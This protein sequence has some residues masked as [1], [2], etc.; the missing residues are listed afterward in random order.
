MATR[1][2]G[3]IV[4]SFLST[5]DCAPRMAGCVPSFETEKR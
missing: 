3:L 5:S 2:R 1:A 4:W